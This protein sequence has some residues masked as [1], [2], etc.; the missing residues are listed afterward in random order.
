MLIFKSSSSATKN[1]KITEVRISCMGPPEIEPKCKRRKQAWEL[2]WK[3]WGDCRTLPFNN[4]VNWYCH[5]LK[6]FIFDLI[7]SL[8]CE[9]AKEFY[10]Y[11]IFQFWL[12]NVP[13]LR[14]NG[15]KFLCLKLGRNH[16]NYCLDMCIQ[17]MRIEQCAYRNVCLRL[18]FVNKIKCKRVVIGE[19]T[20]TFQADLPL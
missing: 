4:T 5:Q 20:F 6:L 7:L 8:F 3:Y 17:L 15:S 12:I 18:L 11:K 19:G 10:F 9:N 1:W 14:R 16:V 13:L 2:K